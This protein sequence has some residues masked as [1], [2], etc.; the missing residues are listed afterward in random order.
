MRRPNHNRS[1]PHGAP[2]TVELIER[3][4]NGDQRAWSELV[5]ATHRE[6]YTLCLRI[7]KDPDDAA[8][9]TQ[10]AFLKAWR[11]LG[12]FRG[13]ALFTTWLY[14]VAT[15]AAISKHRSRKR[16][17]THEAGTEHEVL[18]RVAQAGSTE[19]TA[20]ARAGLENLERALLGLPDMYR[21][22]LVMKD[23]YGESVSEIAKKLKISETATKV[24]LHRARKKLK[25]RVYPEAN[26]GA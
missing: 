3:C 4:R 18:E 25:E 5:E 12:S 7:L 24:R 11:G 9:A 19:E 22:P 10:D 15:N 21:L 8:E 17:R 16:R 20:D 6:V 1:D 13:E 2:V 26:E 14:R 23:V